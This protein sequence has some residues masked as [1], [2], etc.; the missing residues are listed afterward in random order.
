MPEV[1]IIIPCFNEEGTIGSLLKA[2]YEQSYPR[3]EIE[4]IIADGNSTDDTREVIKDFANEH[5][6]LSITVLDNPKRNIPTGLNLAIKAGSGP[7]ILRLDAHSIPAADYVY[8][9]INA[10]KKRQGDIVGGVWE[11]RPGGDDWISRSIAAAAS[12]PIGV[13]D[14]RYRIGGHAHEVDTVPFGAYHRGLVNRIGAYDENLLSNEDYEFSVRA[15]Q[16][17]GVIW[18]DPKISSIY[19]SRPTYKSLAKQYWRYGYWKLRMLLRYP[20]TFRWRQL[21]GVFVLTWPILGLLSIWFPLAR[22]AI[23]LEAILYGLILTYAGI[24]S[25]ITK[26]DL[27][28]IVGV[29]LAVSIMHFSWGTAFLWSAI[30][31]LGMMGKN[32]HSSG[33]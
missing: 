13:G 8:L 5:M 29:P 4:V 19:F 1:S 15:Q 2:V 9:C 11:I 20:E 3:V 22:W 28:Y 30:E 31:F 18:M 6:D 26:N 7:Y 12:H 33:D 17:G 25:A 16:A 24:Q 32:R 21:A 10:L 23:T 14:A 27:A